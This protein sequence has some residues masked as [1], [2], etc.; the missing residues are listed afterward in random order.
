MVITWAMSSSAYTFAQPHLISVRALN[1]LEAEHILSDAAERLTENANRDHKASL[2][3]KTVCLAFFEDSTRTR[4]SF[5]LAAKR[6]GADVIA[7]AETGSSL[8]KGESFYDT[9]VTLDAMGA[10]IIVVRHRAAGAAYMVAQHTRASV[11]NAGD[12]AHEHPTQA[13]L[14]ALTLTSKLGS[15]EGKIIT[16]CGDVRH[17]RVARSNI[18]LLQLLGARVRLAAPATLLPKGVSQWGVEVYGSTLEAAKGADVLMA[19]RIQNERMDGEFVPSVREYRQLFAIDEA[20]LAA[21]KPDAYVMHPGPINRGVEIA[22]AIADDAQASLVLDQV[23]AGVAVRSAV[24]SLLGSR[25][26]NGAPP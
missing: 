26:S 21:A 12:G 10:D 18:T 7:F 3:G 20:A 13:L 11:V 22:D 15:L 23:R 25:P 1:R 5:E 6:Q 4:L 24:L 2:A 16:I 17:S 14:D 8:S 19:L 9:M